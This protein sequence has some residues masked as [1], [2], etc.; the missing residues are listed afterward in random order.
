MPFNPF[1]PTINITQGNGKAFATAGDSQQLLSGGVASL[2]S[3]NYF[4]HTTM[5]GFYYQ[6]DVVSANVRGTPF[7]LNTR[8]KDNV[9][10]FELN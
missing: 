6:Q 8:N 4:N 2:A 10:R 3:A 1:G 5:S 7:D 9:A